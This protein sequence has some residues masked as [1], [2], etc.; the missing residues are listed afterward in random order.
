VAEFDRVGRGAGVGI[1]LGTFDED[2]HHGI[3]LNVEERLTIVT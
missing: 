1:V 2:G 3:A